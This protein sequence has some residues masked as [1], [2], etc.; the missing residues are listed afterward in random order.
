MRDSPSQI[1]SSEATQAAFESRSGFR[2]KKSTGASAPSL[3]Q[4]RDGSPSRPIPAAKPPLSP[5]R[6][7]LRRLNLGS[8]RRADPTHHFSK[9]ASAPSLPQGRDGSPSRP[10][11][12]AK[13]P[14]SPPK[15]RVNQCLSKSHPLVHFLRRWLRIPISQFFSGATPIVANGTN[16]K[17]SAESCVL[18]D[19]WTKWC[20][21]VQLRSRAFTGPCK[22]HRIYQ[23]GPHSCWSLAVGPISSRLEIFKKIKPHL[24]K[25]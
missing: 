25:I 7:R 17:R 10:I 2:S 6:R 12:A 13:P 4:G 1:R 19:C 5:P 22:V 3:P 20:E 8:A 23:C 15:P 9:G 21:K 24:G 14:P 11:P 16:E 18:F